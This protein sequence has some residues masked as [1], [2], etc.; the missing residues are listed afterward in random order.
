MNQ[1][2]I[3]GLVLAGGKSTRMNVDKSLLFYHG[4]TQVEHAFALLSPH[5]AKVFVSNRREQE[6][7]QGH[8]HL[9][10]LHDLPEYSDIGP[11][12]GVLSALTKFPTA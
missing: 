10:Q 2:N 3:Y 5:C 11:L 12:G 9:P 8:D 7:L 1:N 6:H 4:K